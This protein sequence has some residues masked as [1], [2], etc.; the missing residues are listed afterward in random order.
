MSRLFSNSRA[1]TPFFDEKV[2]V[3]GRRGDRTVRVVCRASVIDAGLADLD[4]DALA[5]SLEHAYSVKVMRDDWTEVDPP[6]RGDAIYLENGQPMRVTSVERD[7]GW[8]EITAKTKGGA[9]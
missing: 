8:F 9:S 2:L 5:E 4:A 1:F 7:I 6:Q 3:E